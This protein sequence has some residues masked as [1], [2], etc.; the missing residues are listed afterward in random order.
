MH[1]MIYILC[2]L[3][4][5]FAAG[6]VYYFLL[7]DAFSLAPVGKYHW[8][9][10]LVVEIFYTMAL[11]YVVLNCACS[12]KGEGNQFFGLAIGFTV[13][14]AALAIGGLSG[15]SLNPAVSFGATA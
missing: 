11:C 13:V 2:Q 6:M 3:A 4:G 12:T 10:A 9:A 5:G 7:G 15:C 14:A 1:A 8:A